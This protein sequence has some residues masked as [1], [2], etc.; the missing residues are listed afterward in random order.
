MVHHPE[1]SRALAR[2]GRQT[3]RQVAIGLLL[4]LTVAALGITRSEAAPPTA[5]PTVAARDG[6]HYLSTRV[7]ADGFI[8]GETSNPNYGLTL[9]AALALAQA[10]V[11]KPT[12]DRIVAW[13]QT[14]ADAA[15]RNGGADDNPGNLGYLLMIATAAGIDPTSFGGKNLPNRL[16]ATLGTFP[17]QAGLYGNADPTF[18]GVF[19]Q[20]LAILGL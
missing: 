13:L 1:P 14:H 6:A 8:P 3:R 7:N 11:E 10:A 9:D 5:D 4:A 15:I 19:R 20:S 2:H 16:A 17:T 12:F 18:D